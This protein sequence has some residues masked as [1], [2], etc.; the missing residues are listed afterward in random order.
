MVC[1]RMSKRVSAQAVLLMG[2]QHGWQGPEGEDGR[3]TFLSLVFFPIKL[4]TVSHSIRTPVQ[5]I[6][7]IKSDFESLLENPKGVLHE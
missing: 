6:E 5:Y 3:A 7:I 2:Y 1:P 4:C